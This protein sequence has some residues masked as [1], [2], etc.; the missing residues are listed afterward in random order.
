M[1]NGI[2]QGC[3]DYDKYQFYFY[4]YSSGPGV[5]VPKPIRLFCYFISYS[6]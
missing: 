4:I 3:C 1:V 5:V 2:K 6:E